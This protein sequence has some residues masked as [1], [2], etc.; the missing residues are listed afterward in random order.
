[1]AECSS[2]VGRSLNAEIPSRALLSFAANIASVVP[3]VKKLGVTPQEHFPVRGFLCS[4]KLMGNTPGEVLRCGYGG[5]EQKQFGRRC[6]V[7]RVRRSPT[8]MLASMVDGYGLTRD[9]KTTALARRL[10]SPG[11]EFICLGS[12]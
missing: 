9:S 3:P 4:C 6:C 5:K 10:S 7:A 8:S 12:R 2:R 1:M 11:S